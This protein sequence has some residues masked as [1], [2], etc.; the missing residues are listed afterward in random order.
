[1]SALQAETG[2]ARLMFRRFRITTRIPRG[3]AA[4]GEMG[5]SPDHFFADHVAPALKEALAPLLDNGDP[6]VWIIRR[7]DVKILGDRASGHNEIGRV[8]ARSFRQMMMRAFNGEDDIGAIRFPDRASYL[9]QFLTDLSDGRAWDRWYYRSFADLRPLPFGPAV[10][11]LIERKQ[12]HALSA[13]IMMDERGRLQRLVDQL[14]ENDAHQIYSALVPPAEAGATGHS[15]V[16]A[17]TKTILRQPIVLA[18]GTAYRMRL[19]L[20][21]TAA[22]RL[23][24]PPSAI[25]AA[26]EAILAELTASDQAAGVRRGIT[27]APN[28]AARVPRSRRPLVERVEAMLK[29]LRSDDHRAT[30]RMAAHS[31]TPSFATPFAGVFLLWRSAVELGLDR[32]VAE[33]LNARQA[34]VRRLALAARLTGAQWRAALDDEAVQWLA[35]IG[36]PPDEAETAS[37]LM[38]SDAYHA[39][40]SQGLLAKLLSLHAPRPLNLLL[41]RDDNVVVLQDAERQDWLAAA[42]GEVPDPHFAG[43]DIGWLLIGNDIGPERAPSPCREWR[44]CELPDSTFTLFTSNAPPDEKIIAQARRAFAALRPPGGDL[45][46]FDAADATS[47]RRAALLWAVLA[48]AAYSDLGR[49]LPGLELSSAHYLARNVVQGRGTF[50][51]RIDDYDAEVVLPP[52]SMDLVLRM[53]GLD[54]TV[55][56]LG[57]GRS[58]LLRLPDSGH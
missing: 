21:V 39:R 10:C 13:L 40:I 57:D 17:I 30:K 43:V 6:A 36:E 55:L 9:A 41:Q 15:Q 44:R 33:G 34:S 8:F 51:R 29:R 11:M 18:H 4:A 19:V 52:A 49:R 35:G 37:A 32:I 54:R 3:R 48:R 31:A 23:R 46:Y 50:A 14:G 53:T 26:I 12:S 38:F 7:L 25:A 47:D 42:I 45:I 5:L 28:E 1:M 22:T 56:R 24:L 16:I 58:V 20:L 27:G 2:D